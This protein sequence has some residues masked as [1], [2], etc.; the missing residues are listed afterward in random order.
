MNMTSGKFC[1]TF[2]KKDVCKIG[3][4]FLIT[5]TVQIVAFMQPNVVNDI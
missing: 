3:I 5:K 4:L 2:M 1:G